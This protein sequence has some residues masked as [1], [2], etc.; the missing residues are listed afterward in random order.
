[1]RRPAPDI[2]QQLREA[3]R[4][5]GWSASA[6]G[7]WTGLQPATIT[8]FLRGE[9]GITLDT[10]ARLAVRLNLTLRPRHTRA[11]KRPKVTQAPAD[12]PQPAE[13]TPGRH[14]GL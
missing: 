9:R 11:R 8:R 7:R 1:M 10:A 4:A 3:I 2:R 5:F 14:T 13:T 6:L 12:A